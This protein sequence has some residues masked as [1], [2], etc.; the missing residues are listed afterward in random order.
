MLRRVS[1][2]DSLVRRPIPFLAALLLVAPVLLP[3]CDPADREA[4]VSEG[5][6]VVIGGALSADNEEVYRE[7][8]DGKEGEGP[9]C[10]IPTAGG[11]PESSMNSAVERIERWGGEGSARGIFI[12]TENPESALDPEVAR[13]LEG[14][15]GFFFTGGAQSRIIDVFRPDGEAT[16]AFDALWGRWQAGAVVSGSSAGAAMMSHP[17]IAGGSSEGAFADG[18]GPEGG[19]RLTEGMNFLPDLLVDQHFLARGRIGRLIVAVLHEP[20]MSLGAGIDENTALVVEGDRAWVAGA[21]GVVLVDGRQA[22][23]GEGSPAHATGVR[24][25]LLGPGDVVDL[26]TLEVRP[27]GGKV[28]VA[29]LEGI[30]SDEIIPDLPEAPG[31]GLFERW[32]FLH[33]LHHLAAAEDRTVV[34]EVA[35]HR[36]S[37]QVAPERRALAYP[38]LGVRG[39]P[40]GLSVGPVEVAVEPVEGSG[41]P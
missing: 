36:V 31:D 9:I 37:F 25:E 6:L 8:L 38:Q 17:M 20:R 4:E 23:R 12:S 21:S 15:S 3:G 24:V 10:V 32:V 40:H 13:E 14:C 29:D 39:T 19:V 5:R 41:P 34:S 27:S 18:G 26:S 7:I 33:L 16:P 2:N 30:E 22:Q 35:G 11:S 28:A 1:H